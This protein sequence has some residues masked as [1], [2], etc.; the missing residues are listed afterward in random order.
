LSGKREKRR[1]AEEARKEGLRKRRRIIALAVGLLIVVA[2]T[3]A[4]PVYL[5]RRAR[6]ASIRVLLPFGDEEPY[7]VFAE[8]LRSG[9]EEYRDLLAGT[10]TMYRLPQEVPPAE[11]DVLI[12]PA[13][14]G[15]L[16]DRLLAVDPYILTLDR[17]VGES[18]LQDPGNTLSELTDW[19]RTLD[20]EEWT[21]FVVAGESREDFAAFALYLAAELLEGDAREAV[22]NELRQASR[23]ARGE[24]SPTEAMA[25]DAEAVESL[26]RRLA[27]V[28]DFLRGWKESGILV[29]NWTNWDRI[30][31]EQAIKEG[32]GALTFQRRSQL[33][34]LVWEE[35]FHLRMRQPPAGPSR[36]LYSMVGKGVSATAG[37]GVRSDAAASIRSLL[38]R[39]AI[40]EIVET[41]TAWSP[42]V[43]EGTPVNREH[44][45]VVRWVS[46]AEEYL[47]LE[48]AVVEH[49]LFRR[50]HQ[51]LR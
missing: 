39:P 8:A 1:R 30:A 24:R 12:G 14:Y 28:I 20:R 22:W 45:D 7:G 37:D 4:I 35:A 42:V 23:A 48:P 15:T 16:Q 43:Q 50:L 2:L 3:V 41:D 26:V 40:Q 32:R 36:R 51:I 11:R 19:L 31:L 47:L 5:S 29:F 17:R 46:G 9:S 33:E 49:P 10:V 34:T 25:G 38:R 21:P 18:P 27:P 6:M 44:R 13:T